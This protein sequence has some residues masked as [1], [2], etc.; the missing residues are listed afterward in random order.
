MYAFCTAQGSTC[1]GFC[2]QAEQ[3]VLQWRELC[4]GNNNLFF[5]GVE[6][7]NLFYQPVS[8][9]QLTDLSA[10]RIVQV[11]VAE[12]IFLALVDELAAIPRQENDRVLRLY[13]LVA[14]LF[15]RVAVNSP[16][17]TSYRHNLA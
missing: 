13:I 11:K 17:S 2:I 12:A 8:L 16:V 5:L 14:L 6:A 9:G 7:Q 3:V 10:V 15:K 1:S 4:A